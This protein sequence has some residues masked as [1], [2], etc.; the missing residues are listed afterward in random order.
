[1]FVSILCVPDAIQLPLQSKLKK[2]K[3]R[4]N[5]YTFY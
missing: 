4:S 1:V 5:N 3:N 2:N